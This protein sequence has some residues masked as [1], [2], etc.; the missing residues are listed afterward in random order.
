V[1]HLKIS[2]MVSC[3]VLLIG[4]GH[5]DKQLAQDVDL[6]IE[7]IGVVTLESELEINRAEAAYDNLSDK[8]KGLLLKED[9]LF[10]ARQDYDQ[11]KEEAMKAAKAAE[12]ER[13]RKEMLT[14]Q[15]MLI[16]ELIETNNYQIALEAIMNEDEEAIRLVQEEIS[17]AFVEAVKS[18]R[19]STAY[20]Q[21]LTANKV[22]DDLR[23]LGNGIKSRTDTNIEDEMAYIQAVQSFQEKYQPYKDVIELYH[24]NEMSMMIGVVMNASKYIE[25]EKWEEAPQYLEQSLAMLRTIQF[26]QYNKDAYGINEVSQLKQ[27]YENSLAAIQSSMEKF[28][29]ASLQKDVGSFYEVTQKTMTYHEE[30]QNLIE[31]MTDDLKELSK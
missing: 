3:L 26:D 5:K 12:Q 25:P 17:Q 20:Q 15:G 11:L 22:F 23:A 16:V 14:Q 29:L 28:D 8:Q 7:D 30:L 18:N 9:L 27:D 24:S 19:L 31:D 4:C 2:L 10:K 6:L 13:L 1:R 21:A